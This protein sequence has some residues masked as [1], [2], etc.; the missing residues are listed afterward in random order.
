[1]DQITKTNVYFINGK[2][3]DKPIEDM[4]FILKNCIDISGEINMTIPP[5]FCW[6]KK[7]N[8]TN[9]ISNIQQKELN[10]L[11]RIS[12]CPIQLF[13]VDKSTERKAEVYIKYYTYLF[14]KPNILYNEI[15]FRQFNYFYLLSILFL[16]SSLFVL[17]L[18]IDNYNIEPK[19]I[20][21]CDQDLDTDYYLTLCSNLKP[22]YT[23][24]TG[25]QIIYK[26]DCI[27]KAEEEKVNLFYEKYLRILGKKDN[28]RDKLL[29]IGYIPK[30]E[31]YN[32]TLGHLSINV[33]INNNYN[34]EFILQYEL[35]NVEYS[36]SRGRNFFSFQCEVN[37]DCTKQGIEKVGELNYLYIKYL[38]YPIIFGNYDDLNFIVEFEGAKTVFGP[39]IIYI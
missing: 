16:S 14:K 27:T 5:E 17:F 11:I 8:K 19:K 30:K 15:I 21:S 22:K 26:E 38:E 13:T 10:P 29:E 33:Y 23:F 32:K 24:Y 34:I 7:F 2:K 39:E 12:I 31:L 20:C 37:L 25:D 6:V 18:G 3:K 9:K 4:E 35:K 1:M 36:Y 28:I